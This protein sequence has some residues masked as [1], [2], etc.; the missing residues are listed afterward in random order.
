MLKGPLA[1]IV[2]G[3]ELYEA[4]VIGMMEAQS[5]EIQNLVIV[6]PPH[7]HDVYLYWIEP[8][9]LGSL[10]SAPDPVE[11]IT[12]GNAKKFFFLPAF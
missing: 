3:H 6:Y 9:S 11:L 4:N 12:T 7:H 2:N 1:I 10:D 8:D 5:S